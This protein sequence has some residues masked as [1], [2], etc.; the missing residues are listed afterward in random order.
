M[1]GF[2]RLEP[3]AHTGEV[4]LSGDACREAGQGGLGRRSGPLPAADE[5]AL[6]GGR[7]GEVFGV[8]LRLRAVVR[9]V[10][11]VVAVAVVVVV[12]EVMRVK[13]AGGGL[14][15]R[16]RGRRGRRGGVGPRSEA[17]QARL[18]TGKMGKIRDV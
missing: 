8:T 15:L 11:V 12:Q 13:E 3:R 10:A 6:G 5:S 4:T 16:R 2:D 7:G 1:L 9:V 18:F 14:Q 17:V